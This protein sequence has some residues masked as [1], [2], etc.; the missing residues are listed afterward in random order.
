VPRGLAGRIWLGV[1]AVA[2]VALVGTGAG[3][4]VALRDAHRDATTASLA[5]LVAPLQ[6]QI[7]RDANGG[8]TAAD[9]EDLQAAVG[10]D[11][12]VHV[13]LP[14]RTFGPEDGRPPDD[15]LDAIG[16]DDGVVSGEFTADGTRFVYAGLFFGGVTGQ[17][18]LVLTERD[19][20]GAAA[21]GEVLRTLPAV[22]AVTLLVGGL[23]AWLLA[24]SVRDPL[25]RLSRATVDV[26]AA[27]A[28]PVTPSGPT[29]VQ[30]LAR[31][32]N[33][34]VDEL[35]ATRRHED[36]LLANLRHDLRTP[37]TVIG[38]YATALLD[39]TA[40]GAAATRAVEA[41]ADE[42]DRL[43]DLVDEL[44]AVEHYADGAAAL[45][46]EV[47]DAG[48][49]VVAAR[50]RFLARAAAGG[51]ELLVVEEQAPA[52]RTFAGDRVAIDR[53]IGNLVANAIGACQSGGH[54]WLEARAAGD[55]SGQPTIA[56]LVTDDGPGFPP[57]TVERVFDRFFRA[58][59]SRSG[60]GSGLGLAI[61]RDLAQAHGGTAHA[62]N[63]APHGARVSVVLPVVP[64][65]T[66]ASA[67]G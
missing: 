10:P 1:A 12:A 17:R 5:A 40:T 36:E 66:N 61:V 24:R 58:D 47:L 2:L 44:G 45:R 28:T 43:T 64:R 33:A 59:P 62:E 25:R 22:V 15:V 39:G 32:F 7:R 46:P 16:R 29:E 52:D 48:A 63:V 11:V 30:D 51:V 9:V 35:E 14:A 55:P 42:A 6:L 18:R 13:F 4:F 54:V 41:I 23:V 26:P 3:L 50:E 60:P 19:V 8:L 49:I 67:D 20:S 27:R 56:F 38:G 34:M 53:L 31:R 65:A 57:G 21:I 37:L